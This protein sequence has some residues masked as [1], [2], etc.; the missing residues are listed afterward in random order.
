MKPAFPP[1]PIHAE[2]KTLYRAAILEKDKSRICEKVSEAE[3]AILGRGRDLFYS[4]ATLEEREA[5]DDALYALR[6]LR[7][8]CEH[9]DGSEAA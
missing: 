2:W 8:A 7:S 5:L 9:S 4:D 6:A 1:V 3:S